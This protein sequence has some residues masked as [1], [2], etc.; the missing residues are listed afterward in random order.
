MLPY[1]TWWKS[2]YL[3]SYS[4]F[5]Q[6][7]GEQR[8]STCILPK[9]ASA[10]A[11][12]GNILG[13]TSII[14]PHFS[15]WPHAIKVSLILKIHNPEFSGA[16]VS[17]TWKKITNIKHHFQSRFSQKV[18]LLLNCYRLKKEKNFWKVEAEDREFS[19]CL[20]SLHY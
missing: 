19:K 13:S 20:I 5:D 6:I 8:S 12:Q 16:S 1:T 11:H 2:S 14:E 17:K 3:F 18:F 4:R 15:C 9:P 10:S 7:K